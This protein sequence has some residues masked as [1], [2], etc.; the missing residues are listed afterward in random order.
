MNNLRVI[1]YEKPEEKY[2]YKFLIR[3]VITP[4]SA[5]RTNKGF[6]FWAKS[7]NVT[8]ELEEEFEHHQYGKTKIYR[9]KGNIEEQLFWHLSDIPEGAVKFTGLSN[10][11]YVDC[12]YLHTDEGSKIFRPNPNAK[13]VY[14]PM[15]LEDHIEFDK[16][17]G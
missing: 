3:D 11:S 9:A 2:G 7:R 8:L 12:Y 6:D 10:G 15:A 14:V 13:E 17:F 1:A 5:Y 4:V 16:K